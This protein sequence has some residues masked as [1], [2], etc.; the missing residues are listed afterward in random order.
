MVSTS[1]YGTIAS[2]FFGAIVILPIIMNFFRKN[3]FDVKGKTVLLTGASEGMG[4]C[5]A[6]Q[7]S[8]KG[9]NI[10]IV[11]RGIPKLEAALAEIQSAASDTTQRFKL[12]SADISTEDEN[13]RVIAE[14]TAWNS[15]R[16]PDIVWCIAGAARP[17]LF[18]DT[19]TA[20]AK[21]QMDMNFWS[22]WYMG[23]A[24]LSKWLDPSA[25]TG[26]PR[27][28]VFTS[29]VIAFY[30]IAG[31]SPYAP[32]KAAIKSL[33]DTLT[34]EVLLYGEDVK[35]HTVFPATILSPGLE[36]ENSTKP[37][38]TLEI[39]ETDPKQTPEVVAANAIAGLERGDNLVTVGWLGTLMR[40][41]AW[42][43]APRNNWL[44]DTL[45]LWAASIVVLFVGQD[46]DGKVRNHG[47]KHGHPTTYPK[48]S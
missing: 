8:K 45:T 22:C 28:L 12:I 42:G 13:I 26:T 16:A 36:R 41:C 5:V 27:H 44:F 14:A 1:T 3:K 18:L 40:A 19:P 37:D 43:G 33:S 38:I 2:I 9:A 25:S 11:S 20:V 4:K 32:S 30:S 29:S 15:G 48:K 21:Q 39:E 24:I 23:Q 10:I 7:L 35:I 17:L 6:V 46:L 31:Y 34:Q 47:K